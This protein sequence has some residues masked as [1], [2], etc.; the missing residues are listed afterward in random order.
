MASYRSQIKKLTLGVDAMDIVGAGAGLAASTILP[1]YIVKDTSTTSGKLMALGASAAMAIVA[2]FVAKSVGKQS[3][4]AKA[5]V[6]GGMAGTAIT[7]VRMFAPTLLPNPISMGGR[8]L[9]A[10]RPAAA[11]PVS[12]APQRES[13][14]VSLIQ[15]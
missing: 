1:T 15:P 10:P 2:G 14:T 4:L 11:F 6:L 7:A 5:A 12:P 9:T 8:M 13:E 3:G